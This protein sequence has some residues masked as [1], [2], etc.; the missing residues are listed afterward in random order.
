[1]LLGKGT[2]TVDTRGVDRIKY[3]YITSYRCIERKGKARIDDDLEGG[4]GMVLAAL[5]RDAVL[6]Q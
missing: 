4:R 5:V 6:Q 3:S 2:T 1:M